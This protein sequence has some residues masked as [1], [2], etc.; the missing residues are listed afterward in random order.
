MTERIRELPTYRVDTTY[1]F[2]GKTS[3]NESIYST[4][5]MMVHKH[6]SWI[7]FAFYSHTFRIH[8]TYF[9]HMC[10]HTPVPQ[11]SLQDKYMRPKLSLVT[12]SKQSKWKAKQGQECWSNHPP[13]ATRSGRCTRAGDCSAGNCKLGGTSYLKGRKELQVWAKWSL[14]GQN[15]FYNVRPW[16]RRWL[17]DN[18][19]CL[20]D[21]LCQSEVPQP[22]VE[23]EVG[24]AWHASMQWD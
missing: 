23:V 15:G 2:R 6:V 5:Q 19:Q 4:N 17:V 20:P 9:P 8:P 21:I 1:Y 13:W 16:L 10:M 22:A 12:N 11:L 14:Q 7:W 18:A 3:V 24:K